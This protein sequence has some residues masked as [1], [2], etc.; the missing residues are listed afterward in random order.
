MVNI[1]KQHRFLTL[2]AFSFLLVVSIFAI[3]GGEANA[4]YGSYG[5][6]YDS[7]NNNCFPSGISCTNGGAVPTPSA[8][9][10]WDNS[11]CSSCCNA[12][13]GSCV[14]IAGP[15][16]KCTREPDNCIS[17]YECRLDGFGSYTCQKP[18]DCRV[19]GC[20]G[21][22]ECRLDGFGSYT[23]QDPPL[24]DD[25]EACGGDDECKSGNCEYKSN[26]GHPVCWPAIDCT[27]EKSDGESCADS[28]QCK[29]GW[30]SLDDPRVCYTPEETEPEPECSPD[31]PCP[32]GQACTADGTC[33]CTATSCPKGEICTSSGTCGEPT[34]KEYGLVP[35]GGPL[36]DENGNIAGQDYE[37]TLKHVFILLHDVV[38]FLIFVIAPILATLMIVYGG[39]RILTAGGSPGQVSKGKNIL[40]WAVIGYLVI[41]LA[42]ITVNTLF[43]FI[44]LAE[45]L[46]P[47][48]WQWW[49]P[50]F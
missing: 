20:N 7:P 33:S 29:S 41:L 25:G 32:E 10:K 1:L 5:C 31:K 42:W 8:C 35:C 46:G 28:C 6:S 26:Y 23:C 34:N 3:F 36:Y 44:G 13:T 9:D 16:E 19:T 11:G 45:W 14:L 50:T 27:L 4:Q 17:G 40:T 43:T 37:C 39:I 2:V 12:T 24:K 15:G 18:S 21:E 22:K 49:R 47:D 30:C 38:D 48:K